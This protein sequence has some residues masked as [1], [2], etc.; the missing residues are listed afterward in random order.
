M[1]NDRSLLGHLAIGTL[2]VC[3]PGQKAGQI[4]SKNQRPDVQTPTHT[5]HIH[6]GIMPA[7]KGMR[8]AGA[9]TNSTKSTAPRASAAHAD[10][11]VQTRRKTVKMVHHVPKSRREEELLRR[12]GQLQGRQHLSPMHQIEQDV[13]LAELEAEI[14]QEVQVCRCA[15]VCVLRACVPWCTTRGVS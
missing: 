2:L 12:R 13:E 6:R 7:Q 11:K 15:G 3:V 10:K 14:M 1:V 4:V 5:S 9:S 8:G